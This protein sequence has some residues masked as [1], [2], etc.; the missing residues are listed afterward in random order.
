M[1]YVRYF[2][3]LAATSVV[4]QRGAS[5]NLDLTDRDGFPAGE[6]SG[7]FFG[8]LFFFSI[9]VKFI[10]IPSLRHVFNTDV[11]MLYIV[12]K[13]FIQIKMFLKIKIYM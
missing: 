3:Q 1:V 4:A 10:D 9:M 13:R 5:R 8:K 6:S 11:W 12:R 7:F 2:Y